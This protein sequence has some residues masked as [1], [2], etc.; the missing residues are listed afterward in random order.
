[1]E[2]R[3]SE[4]CD[5]TLL[6]AAV[7]FPEHV[8]FRSFA[9]ET[10]ALNLQTGKFHGLNVTAGRMVELVQRSGCPRAAVPVLAEEYAV[11]PERIERDLAALLTMLLDRELILL[12]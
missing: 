1:M 3:V 7:R 9:A 6:D 11:A 4:S 12:V 8:V 5:L 2:R 10:V